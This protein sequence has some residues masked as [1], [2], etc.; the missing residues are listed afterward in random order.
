MAQESNLYDLCH[1]ES[2]KSSKKQPKTLTVKNANDPKKNLT[3][4]QDVK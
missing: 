3:S 4:Y 1:F 2:E